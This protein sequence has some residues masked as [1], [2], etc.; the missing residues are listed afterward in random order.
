MAIAEANLRARLGEEL[1]DHYIFGLC[2]DGDM[3]EGISHEAASMAGHLGLG[4][5]VFVYDDN[6]I[7]IDGHT[8]LAFSDDTAARFRAYDWHVIELGNKGEDLDAIETAIREGMAETSKPTMIVLETEIGFPA[9]ESAGTHQVHGYAI[10]DDEIAA[11][12]TLMGLDPAEVF[13]VAPE[14]ADA[15]AAAGVQHRDLFEAWSKRADAAR[16]DSPEVVALMDGTPVDGWQDDLPTWEA[17]ASV[18]TRKAS[19]AVVQ[20]LLE[21]VPSLVGGGAD[22]TG[23]TGTTIKDEGVFTA[24]TGAGRQIYY[25]IREHAMGA[26]MVGMAAHGGMIPIGGTFLVF[27]DYMRGAVRLAALSRHRTV[28]VWTHDSVGVG[29]DGPTHQPVEHVASLRAMPGLDVWRPA[30]AHETNASWIAAITTDGPTALIMSRQGLPVFED[31]ADLTKSARG[32]YVLRDAGE[33]AVILTG[34]G[35]EVQHCMDAAE[36]LAADGISA[37]VVSMPCIEVFDRQDDAYRAS[38]FPSGIPVVSIEAGSTMGWHRFADTAL[39]I[40]RFGASAPG[41]TVM[42]KLGMTAS[43]VESAARELLA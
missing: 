4:K 27:S 18:A 21:K 15:C 12:K 10:L 40:D 22:L 19:G 35:S 43:A 41:G 31:S 29:E 32:G 38:V 11:T 42:E 23:N 30:D 24:E 17:G 8:D 7:S 6:H 2:S 1:C 9:T 37:R 25:G 34:A 36:A 33:P 14:V 16:S 3:Q 28:F 5:I 39:G 26:A 20:A 13:A